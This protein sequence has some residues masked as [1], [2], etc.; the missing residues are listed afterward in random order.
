MRDSL[1][2]VMDSIVAK[3]V[4]FS[5]VTFMELPAGFFGSSSSMSDHTLGYS[6]QSQALW[7]YIKGRQKPKVCMP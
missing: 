7:A 2:M 5:D 4:V 6:L 1:F 3:N